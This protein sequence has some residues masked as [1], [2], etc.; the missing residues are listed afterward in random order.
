MDKVTTVWAEHTDAYVIGRE[1]RD[2]EVAE[3]RASLKVANRRIA[4]LRAT[5]SVALDHLGFGHGTVI[6]LLRRALRADEAKGEL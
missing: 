2:E 1:S 5:I 6:V 3:L 4:A